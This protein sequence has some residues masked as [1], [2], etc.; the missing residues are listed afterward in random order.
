MKI[1]ITTGGSQLLTQIACLRHLGK[2]LYKYE[3]YY[4]G[5]AV[6]E[7]ENLLSKI[8]HQFHLTYKGRFPDLPIIYPVNF[9]NFFKPSTLKK[10]V[11][12]N[13]IVNYLQDKVPLLREIKGNELVIPFRNKVIGDV[14]LLAALQPHTLLLTADGVINKINHRNVNHWR[15]YGIKTKINQIPVATKVYTPSY[16]AAD[17]K[18][19]GPIEVI[20]DSC[21]YSIFNKVVAL[22]IIASFKKKLFLNGPPKSIIFSQHLALIKACSETEELKLYKKIIHDLIEKGDAP[23]VFKPHPRETLA[24]SKRLSTYFSA[25]SNQITFLSQKDQVI[26]IE[27][28]YTLFQEYLLKLITLSSSAPLSIR[29]ASTE[30]LVYTADF[31][32]TNLKEEI[33]N[34]AAKY[35]GTIR[36][37]TV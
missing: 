16:L 26:P 8:C 9:R 11:V 37:L 17:N 7:L 24:K 31:L 18:K 35:N 34:Y 13:E 1:I 12:K 14:F 4:L 29:N 10:L 5:I 21:L 28:F 20:P 3:V 23:I 19:I 2:L 36:H 27:L 15:W 6:K 25:Y 30:L 33:S 32:P 22:D